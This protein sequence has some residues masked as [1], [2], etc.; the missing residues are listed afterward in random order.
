[1]LL[2]LAMVVWKPPPHCN[3]N[4]HASTWFPSQKLLDLQ[5]TKDRSIQVENNTSFEMW[6]TKLQQVVMPTLRIPC[7]IMDRYEDYLLFECN[8]HNV[9]IYPHTDMKVETRMLPFCIIEEDIKQVVTKWPENYD[10]HQMM[11]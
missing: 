11:N 2:L 7:N 8:F 9:F 3:Y 6:F 5:H 10:P 1:V 4:K